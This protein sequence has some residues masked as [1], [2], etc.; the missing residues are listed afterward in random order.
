MFMETKYAI[1]LASLAVIVTFVYQNYKINRTIDA[2][3]NLVDVIHD[4][5]ENDIQ[6]DVNEKFEE[7]VQEFDE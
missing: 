7:I 2:L 1:G 6:E 3:D 5:M 4:W